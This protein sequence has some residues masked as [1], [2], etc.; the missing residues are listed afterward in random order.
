MALDQHRWEIAV[1]NIADAH[2]VD[3]ADGEACLAQDSEVGIPRMVRGRQQVGD[4]RAC[5]LGAPPL[6]DHRRVK[7]RD[8]EVSVP[9]NSPSRAASAWMPRLTLAEGGDIERKFAG[10]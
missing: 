1:W 5:E 6:G 3:A 2:L 9:R 8:E 7:I 10:C 4:P